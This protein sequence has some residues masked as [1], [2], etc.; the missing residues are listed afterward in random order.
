MGIAGIHGP[1]SAIPRLQ[2]LIVEVTQRCNHGCLHCYNVW[3]PGSAAQPADYPRG[4]LGTVE[5]LALLAKALDE[6]GCRHVTLTGGEPLLRPDLP[7]IVDFLRWRGATTTVISNGRLLTEPTVIELLE[8]GVALF[9]L[10]LLSHR[11]QIHDRLSGA[12]GAFDA[13]LAAMAHIR[14]HRGQFVAVFVVTRENLADLGEAIKLAVAFGARGLMLNRFNPGGRGRNHLHEL[15]PTIDGLRQALEV[16]DGAAAALH[17]PISCSIP[18][19]PCLVDTRAYPHL[20]FG[21]CAAGSDRAY[22]TLDPLG[23]LR[24]CNHTPTIL[25]NLFDHSFAELV[26]T[27]RMAEF[28]AATPPFC[29]PCSQRQVC[30][31][32]CR[33]SAQVCCGSLTAQDPFLALG[34]EHAAPL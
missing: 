23:N 14:F 13:V 10:P 17:F 29:D 26:A 5:M 33:A 27:E 15:L 7:E 24:P 3:V 20:G 12:P 2:T 30:Q 16:A 22:Y 34:R 4:E 11:R 9:E 1:I 6:T 25:G 32:G 18:I 19:Q 8:R 31:G 21:F 28:V